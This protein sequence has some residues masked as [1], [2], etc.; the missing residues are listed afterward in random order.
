VKNHRGFT[1]VE[2]L[3]SMVL[4]SMVL[5]ISSNAYSLFSQ[6][7]NGRLG[8]FNQSVAQ[9]KNLILVQESLKSII[10]Y[11]VTNDQQQAK[12]YFEGNR[13]GFVAVTLRSLYTPE[14][15]AVIRIQITQNADF[16]YKLVYQEASMVSELL[17]KATQPL[18]FSEPIILFNNISNAEFEYFGWP[19]GQSKFWT[20]DSN[21]TEPESKAWFDEYNSLERNIQPEQIRI[22]F[23]TNEG[24][25]SLQAKLN[26]SVPGVL[27][28]Y[29]EQE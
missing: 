26:D 21:S 1:L 29:A 4:L 19:T 6:N 24:A 22:T 15:A 7:W 3:V 9:A 25:Y 10:S 11:V 5:L 28:N 23:T 2:M 16:S 17:T 14:V 27:F 12:F 13:N 18:S 8:H 20:P